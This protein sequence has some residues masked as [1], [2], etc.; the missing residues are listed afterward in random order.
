MPVEDLVIF[1]QAIILHALPAKRGK[2]RLHV[3]AAKSYPL[4]DT[5]EPSK[6]ETMIEGHDIAVSSGGC[7]SSSEPN[8]DVVKRVR[9]EVGSCGPSRRHRCRAPVKP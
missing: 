5:P 7:K 8:G 9:G 3:K 6:K 4:L 1:V 2:V